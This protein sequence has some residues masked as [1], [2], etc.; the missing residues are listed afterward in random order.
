MQHR[1]D[2]GL[3]LFVEEA[4]SRSPWSRICL[5][6]GELFSPS[7]P[8]RFPRFLEYD[9]DIPVPKSLVSDAALSV[10]QPLVGPGSAAAAAFPELEEWRCVPVPGHTDHMVALWHAPSR[11]LYAADALLH[12]P[13]QPQ[14]LQPPVTIDFEALYAASVERL[15]RLPVRHLLLAHGGAFRMEATATASEQKESVEIKDHG[16]EAADVAR[17][18]VGGDWST[19]INAL[20]TRMRSKNRGLKGWRATMVGILNLPTLLS[21]RLNRIRRSLKHLD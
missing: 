1:V 19:A 6:L 14:A 18:F 2:M 11:T 8:V 7:A 3:V 9:F 4:A 13:H 20:A 15:A 16:K 10:L 17:L 5:V 12:L 21:P